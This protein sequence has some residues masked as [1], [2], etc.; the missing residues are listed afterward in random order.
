M[1][2][3]VK[4]RVYGELIFLI[5][6]VE[7]GFDIFEDILISYII[8]VYI[9]VICF[10]LESDMKFSFVFMVDKLISLIFLGLI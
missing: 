6:E 5:G 2:E 7:D 4:K 8:L 9:G 3:I 1:M 10:W